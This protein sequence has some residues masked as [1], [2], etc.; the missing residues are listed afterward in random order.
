MMRRD[1]RL[2]T[3]LQQPQPLAA[4]DGITLNSL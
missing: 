4:V 3:L 1:S 2:A